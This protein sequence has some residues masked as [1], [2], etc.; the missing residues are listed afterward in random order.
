M[1]EVYAIE[2]IKYGFWR[3]HF[4]GPCPRGMDFETARDLLNYLG[5]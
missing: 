4:I 3:L 2:R 5:L 1:R